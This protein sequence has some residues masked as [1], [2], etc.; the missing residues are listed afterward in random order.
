M[1]EWV[2]FILIFLTGAILLY[3]YFK[4]D[5]EPFKDGYQFEE[6]C[7]AYLRARGHKVRNVKDSR[8][9]GADLLSTYRGKKY[10][11][12]CKLNYV[13]SPDVLKTVGSGVFYGVDKVG[14]MTR[15]RFSEPARVV[16]NKTGV[17]LVKVR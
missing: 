17:I 9:Y 6:F 4:R 1:L 7:A 15:G 11:W 2:I 3:S 16:A 13:G 5:S 10:L 8:D 14:V 12:Q